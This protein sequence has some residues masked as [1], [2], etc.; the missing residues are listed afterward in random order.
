MP[1]NC[2][3]AHR[4]EPAGRR[5]DG[6]RYKGRVLRAGFADDAM[7]DS[8]ALWVAA[9]VDG[10]RQIFEVPR[11]PGVGHSAGTALGASLS[12]GYRPD[13]WNIATWSAEPNYLKLS[14][15]NHQWSWPRST[16]RASRRT[17]RH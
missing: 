10:P 16:K 5:Q 7:P 8:S 9:D 3:T 2:P 11:A 17:E 15:R 13:L 14:R 12:D 6:E 1:S 4:M